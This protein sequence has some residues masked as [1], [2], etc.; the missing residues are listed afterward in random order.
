MT[1]TNDNKNKLDPGLWIG[2]VLLVALFFV[3]T[4]CN[5]QTDTIPCK[6]DCIKNV[7]VAT[8][9]KGTERIY[10]VYSDERSDINDMIY[11]SKTVY[12]YMELCKKNKIVPNLG[13]R[14][15]NGQITSIVRYKRRY[16]ISK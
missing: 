13:I 3:T 1:V 2:I 6:M 12:N 4:K 14:F 9:Q 16:K 11:V 10:V 5:A 7:V 8:T 15:K